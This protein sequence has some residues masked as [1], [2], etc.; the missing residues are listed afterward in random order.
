MGKKILVFLLFA[1]LLPLA[2]V[3]GEKPVALATSR[4]VTNPRL[5][6]VFMPRLARLS[7]S[8]TP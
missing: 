1:G 5:V 3:A 8:D 7:S 4:M 6:C 2:S